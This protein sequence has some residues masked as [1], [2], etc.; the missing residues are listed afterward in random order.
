MYQLPAIMK[1]KQIALLMAVLFC[2]PAHGQLRDTLNEVRVK[3]AKKNMYGDERIDHFS[4]GQQITHIDSVV[5]QQYKFQN[6]STLLSQ[7]VPVFVKSYG[8]NGLATLNFRGASAAQSQVYWNGIPIQNAALGITDV[9]LLR[10]SSFSQVDI[11]YGGSSALWGSGNVGGALLLNSAP[12]V[13]K[14]EEEYHVGV[15]LAA[16]SFGQHQLQAN[17]SASRQRWYM[18]SNI[19]LQTAKNNFDYTMDGKTYKTVNSELAGLS[20]QLAAAYKAND[21]NTISFA[22]WGQGYNRE[23]PKTIFEQQSVKKQKDVS[24]RVLFNWDRTTA[25]DHR[26]AKLAYLQDYM[27]YQDSA[28]LQDTKNAV[29]QL[30]GEL[31]WKYQFNTHHRILLF[32]PIQYSWM[33]RQLMNDIVS[34]S[35][36]SLAGAYSYAAFNN[37]LQLAVNVRGMLVDSNLVPMLGANASYAFTTWFSIR[38]NVQRSYRV[39]TLNE[40]YYVPGGNDQLKPEQG[41]SKDIGYLIKTNASKRFSIIHDLSYFDRTMHDW[42]IWFGSSIWTPHNIATVHSRGVETENKIQLKAGDWIIHAGVN[43]AYLLAT[44]EQSYIA[45][46]GSI[47]KQIPYSPRYNG[48]LNIGFYFRNIYFNYNHTY[49][50]Y[51]FI[52]VDESSWLMPYNTGNVSAGY[53][54]KLSRSSLQFSLQCNNL[55]NENYFVVS[56]RPMPGRNWLAGISFSM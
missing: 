48:Q 16:G 38:A 14:N 50:G 18:A 46:D 27:H 9:S 7:Q 12:P 1:K 52:T 3:T 53:D 43:T 29:N 2:F 33:R 49:T 40:L 10:T 8:I 5:L 20:A 31:G 35:R 23:I 13:F 44:T 15:S 28:V 17:S 54:L 55:W 45:G 19:I 24:L 32:A 41:W 37:K 34:Q 26:Y 25:K 22:A 6:L 39:P 51:R 56:G 47:G 4:P 30:Y 21:K 36:I 42:I 11:V